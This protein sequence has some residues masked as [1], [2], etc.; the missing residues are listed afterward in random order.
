MSDLSDDLA[1][2]ANRRRRVWIGVAAVSVPA[3][4]MLIGATGHPE[5][6]FWV[7]ALVFPALFVHGQVH[8]RRTREGTDERARDQHRRAAGFS[9]QVMAVVLVAVTAWMQLRHGVRTAEP[10]LVL[11]VTLLA[12]YLIALLWH[13]RRG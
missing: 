4:I 13:R 12:S 2:G 6:G 8:G 3:A 10:Y 9:W 11:T 1:T 5:L 7:I